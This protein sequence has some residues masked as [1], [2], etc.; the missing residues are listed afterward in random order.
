MART[1]TS[2]ITPSSKLQQKK[3]AASALDRQITSKKKQFEELDEEFYSTKLLHDQLKAE[4]ELFEKQT[5]EKILI[6]G[7]LEKN[8]KLAERAKEIRLSEEE[9]L[10]RLRED[11]SVKNKILTETSNRNRILQVEEDRNKE[12]LSNSIKELEE[13]QKIL[14]EKNELRVSL[15]SELINL[16]NDRNNCRSN[17]EN[18]KKDVEKVKREVE[19]ILKDKELVEEEISKLKARSLEENRIFDEMEAKKKESEIEFKKLSEKNSSQESLL[20]DTLE[21]KHS[22][23]DE[24]FE[25]VEAH[26]KLNDE[27]VSHKKFIESANLTVGEKQR[28]AEKLDRQVEQKMITLKAEESKIN[29]ARN[30][31][32]KMILRNKEKID[33]KRVKEFVESLKDGD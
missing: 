10:N 12:T 9:E 23:E 7:E 1:K 22:V 26:N 32:L 33:K 14:V 4:V 25:L 20:K 27:V 30:E 29:N 18:S 31:L 17:L 19:D 24:Y 28:E 2:K 3:E 5:R 13:T 15:E 11:I 16:E 21:K 6:T 8:S